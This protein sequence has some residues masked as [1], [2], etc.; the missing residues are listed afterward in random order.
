MKTPT[1]QVKRY[2]PGNFNEKGD[3]TGEKVRAELASYLKDFAKF[4]GKSK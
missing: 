2:E 4:I 1:I 3:L